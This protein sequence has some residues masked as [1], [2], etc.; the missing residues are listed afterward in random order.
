MIIFT[1]AFWSYAGERA[2]KTVAQTAITALTVGGIAG[3]L[4]VAWVPLASGVALSGILSV[5]TSVLTYTP[6]PT[7]DHAA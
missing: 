5:L 2:S 1:L 7:G 6:A 4:D 3:V